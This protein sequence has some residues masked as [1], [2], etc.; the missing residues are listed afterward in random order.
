MRLLI[1]ILLVASCSLFVFWHKKEQA[2]KVFPIEKQLALDSTVI[3]VSIIASGLDVPWEI[4]WGSDN[5]I[6]MTEQGGTVSRLDPKTGKRKVV[7]NLPDV[8]RKRTMGLLGMAVSPDF[9]KEPYVFLDYTFLNGTNILSR[10][11]RYTYKNDTLVDPLVLLTDIPGANGHNGSRVTIAP[12][13][14]LMLS[15]GDAQVFANAQN[16]ASIN[17]KILRLNIDGTIPDDNPIKGSPVWSLGHRNIQGLAYGPNGTLYSSEHGDAIEDELNIIK[18]GGNYG[19]PQVEGA[20]NL[21]EEKAYC[22]TNNITEPIKSWT[23]TI[24]PA[25]IAFYHSSVMPEWNNSLLLTTLKGSSLY[26]LKLDKSGQKVVSEKV[27]FKETYGRI[28]DVCVSPTG[29]VYLSTSNK[30]WNPSE[31]FPKPKD[32][33]II[34]IT[35]LRTEK[36]AANV[37]LAATAP[38]PVTTIG[39]GNLIYTNYCAACHKKGGEG[40]TGNFPPLKGNPRVTGNKNAL[41]SVVLNG[42]T[43]PIKVKG[44]EYNQPMPAFKFLSDKDVAAVVS[45]IR[46]NMGNK[47]GSVTI[48]DVTKVRKAKK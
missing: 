28:R 6:W 37:T 3:G 44:V 27:Y 2:N 20:C 42:M 45:Y 5:H 46:T 7:L 1:I 11:V 14:K 15:T 43:D 8:Y 4:A 18:M 31:G 19:W 17:G 25:G 35:K 26:V 39:G 9:K 36:K 48:D 12:D 32:D 38:K 24:A 33:R 29:E 47:A 13:G 23:P 10:L 21:D 16:K 30:D 41:I 22:K 40:V 34:R